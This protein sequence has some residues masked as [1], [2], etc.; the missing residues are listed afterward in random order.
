VEVATFGKISRPFLAHN[1]TF[2]CWGSLVAKIGTLYIPGSPP[3]WGFDV[4]LAM[5]L[6]KTFLLRM[7]N[8]S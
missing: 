2:R 5:E 1:S 8:Y 3:S 7:L 6:S 4:P